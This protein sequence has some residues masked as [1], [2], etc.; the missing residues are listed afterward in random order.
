MLFIEFAYNRV[1]HSTTKCTSFEIVYGFNPLTPIDLLPIPSKE[2]V[3]F[4]ANAKVEF[5]HK[6]HDNSL[7]VESYQVFFVVNIALLFTIYS[8]IIPFILLSEHEID[9]CGPT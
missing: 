7:K 2:F 9:Y 1:V 5:V 4:D 8:F 6:L 3:N